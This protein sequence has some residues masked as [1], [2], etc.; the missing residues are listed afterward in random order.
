[1]LFVLTQIWPWLLAALA[2]GAAVGRMAYAAAAR[3]ALRSE[4]PDM[5]LYALKSAIPVIPSAP[6]EVAPSA[7]PEVVPVVASEAVPAAA[8]EVEVVP[9]TPVQVVDALQVEAVH[10]ELAARDA[11]I[12]ELRAG[13]DREVAL[14]RAGI[15]RLEGLM[16]ELASATASNKTPPDTPS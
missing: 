12:A 14:R 5:R 13:L 8:S 10:H 4:L 16:S 2:L 3:L 1:M 6:A 9:A 11:A 7:P 15:A